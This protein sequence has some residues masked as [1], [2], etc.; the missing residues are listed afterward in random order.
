MVR[1]NQLSIIFITWAIPIIVKEEVA[2]GYGLSAAIGACGT[3]QTE[4]VNAY[5]N[6]ASGMGVAKPSANVLEVT[7]SQG[8]TLKKWKDESKQATDSQVA[9]IINDILGDVDAARDLH[10]YGAMNVPGVRTAAKT[11]TTDKNGH[12]K[13]C[14]DCQ[15]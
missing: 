4:L 14:L 2:G 7:N 6:F 11:G 3:K 13:G 12:A 1:Q 15:L 8:D 10:G 9:Y 5:G